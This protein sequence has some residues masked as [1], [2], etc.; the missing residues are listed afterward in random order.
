MG[1]DRYN[2]ACDYQALVINYTIYFVNRYTDIDECDSRPCQNDGTCEDGINLFYCNCTAG[3]NGTTCE[4][5]M[6]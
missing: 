4:T 1:T 3:Y 5:G 6:L 2:H